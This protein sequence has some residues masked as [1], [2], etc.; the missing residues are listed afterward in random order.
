MNALGCIRVVYDSGGFRF[1]NRI[2]M[3]RDMVNMADFILRNENRC[4]SFCTMNP[5]PRV[6]SGEFGRTSTCFACLFFFFVNSQASELDSCP[7]RSASLCYSFC[8]PFISFL[9]VIRDDY[10]S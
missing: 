1:R 4:L 6:G 9:L 5:L 2:G 7:P 8:F 3:D 10:P